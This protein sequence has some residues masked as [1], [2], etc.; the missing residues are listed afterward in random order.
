MRRQTKRIPRLVLVQELAERSE[1]TKDNPEHDAGDTANDQRQENGEDRFPGRR[2]MRPAQA[3]ALEN[4]VV[5][6][7][8]DSAAERDHRKQIGR[9]RRETGHAKS[10]LE[11]PVRAT[12]QHQAEMQNPAANKKPDDNEKR[13]ESRI[14]EEKA[15]GSEP[16]Q[17]KSV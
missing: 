12:D 3:D 13:G 9:S 1:S 4:D 10:R 17:V 14:D 8:D 6:G 5:D 11:R 16:E 7:G 2:L 15:P